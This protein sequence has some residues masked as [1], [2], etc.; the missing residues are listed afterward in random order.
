MG[1]LLSDLALDVNVRREQAYCVGRPA[2]GATAQL[3]AFMLADNRLSELARLG[4]GDRG[5]ASAPREAELAA[6]G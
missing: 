2:L 3:R 4:A 1:R 5:R 6:G